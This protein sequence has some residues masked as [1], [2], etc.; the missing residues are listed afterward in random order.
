VAV[1]FIDDTVKETGVPGENLRS[2]IH[3]GGD[4][5]HFHIDQF[6]GDLFLIKQLDY[7]TDKNYTLQENNFMNKVP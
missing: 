2:V 4:D 5:N 3:S 1:S 6:T 7:E